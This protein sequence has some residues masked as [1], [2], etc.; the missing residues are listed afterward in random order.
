MLKTSLQS[1]IAKVQSATEAKYRTVDTI[2]EHTRVM[3]RAV[4][5]GEV[6]YGFNLQ[7]LQIFTG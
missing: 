4:D 6:S 7:V 3:K 2:N 1:A 5:E